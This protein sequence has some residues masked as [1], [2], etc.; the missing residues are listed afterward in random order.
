MRELAANHM[1]TRQAGRKHSISKGL[2]SSGCRARR[3]CKHKSFWGVFRVCTRPS[4]LARR[5]TS[6]FTAPLLSLQIVVALPLR[7]RSRNF[8]HRA[9]PDVGKELSPPHTRSTTY[10]ERQ[11]RRSFLRL[12]YSISEDFRLTCHDASAAEASRVNTM[13]RAISV[14]SRKADTA[15]AVCIHR[16]QGQNSLQGNSIYIG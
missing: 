7:Q 9:V 5:S 10:A 8:D 1:E 13:N 2:L 12:S 6:S 4:L 14:L 15:A 16:G 3:V 11:Q